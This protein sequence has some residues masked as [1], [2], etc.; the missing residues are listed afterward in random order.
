MTDITENAGYEGDI[1]LEWRG[2]PP[3]PEYIEEV[4]KDIRSSLWGLSSPDQLIT[5][6]VF[7]STS[8]SDYLDGPGVHVWGEKDNPNFVCEYTDKIEWITGFPNADEANQGA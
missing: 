7:L 4:V 6:T 5:H 3:S 1:Q 2:A 8:Q